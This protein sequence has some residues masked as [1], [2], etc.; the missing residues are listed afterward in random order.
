MTISVQVLDLGIVRPLVGNVE[1]GLDG[2]PIRV[3]TLSKE[4]L[5]ELLVQIVDGVIKGQKDKLGDLVGTVTSG[6]VSSSTIAVLKYKSKF[7][8][9]SCL[10][11]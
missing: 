3:V 10:N 1:G 5:V 9:S 11:S 6:D 2:A 4:I 7:Y 8:L